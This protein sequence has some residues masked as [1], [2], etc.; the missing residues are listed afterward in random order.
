M[1]QTV[2]RYEVQ[3]EHGWCGPRGWLH[4]DV[5]PGRETSGH[6]GQ[7]CRGYRNPICFGSH[8]L[9]DPDP[10]HWPVHFGGCHSRHWLATETLPRDFR[11][12][13][14]GFGSRTTLYA[15]VFRCCPPPFQCHQQCASDS[16]APTF[17]GY[18]ASWISRQ[19]LD[20]LCVGGYR[21]GESDHAWKCCK[22]H[23]RSHSWK[24]GRDRL[25]R[26]L[27][28]QVLVDSN[29]CDHLHWSFIAA[30][31]W[32]KLGMDSWTCSGGFD[33]DDGA[34]QKLHNSF[35]LLCSCCIP[36]GFLPRLRTQP[37]EHRLG[38]AVVLRFGSTPWSLRRC[39]VDS[40]LHEDLQPRRARCTERNAAGSSSSSAT[41]PWLPGGCLPCQAQTGCFGECMCFAQ[42][43]NGSLCP[44]VLLVG[45]GF[46]D[47][48]SNFHDPGASGVELSDF[49]CSREFHPAGGSQQCG[50]S[51]GNYLEL[52]GHGPPG[53]RGQ[54]SF[55]G[56]TVESPWWSSVPMAA[57]GLTIVALPIVRHY[58]VDYHRASGM[59]TTESH[60]TE[61]TNKG[62]SGLWT[63]KFFIVNALCFLFNFSNMAQLQLLVQEASKLLPG[64]AINFTSAAQVIAHL[65]M[66]VASVVAGRLADFG[67]KPLVLIA[68]LTVTI[69]ALL[70]AA[71]DVW[72]TQPGGSPWL[73]LLPCETLDGVCAGLWGVLMVLMAKDVS[74]NTGCFS[75]AL[76]CL[77]AGN[78]YARIRREEIL[79][80]NCS[81]RLQRCMVAT[82]NTLR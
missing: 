6:R 19:H 27:L 63:S 52:R 68:C 22:S 21:L 78:G 31:D 30:A 35:R 2:D 16:D 1:D 29:A 46:A 26:D 49:G 38:V 3:H 23:C 71:T 53:Q 59:E 74:E 76:G 18:A 77:Q 65:G 36:P 62:P 61:A 4:A 60:E 73:S 70:T 17:V 79:L 11:T 57:C 12:M 14:K 5:H 55:R 40:Q 81:E 10:L 41:L 58:K 24:W 33:V 42:R 75:L 13:C 44:A 25:C 20:C 47:P 34:L 50:P 80:V 66:L 9:F 72:W 7:G 56:K 37:W 82:W 69:R 54:R 45:D 51:F 48:H 28:Q 67:R 15:L 64:Q 8:W 43:C 32:T 39:L